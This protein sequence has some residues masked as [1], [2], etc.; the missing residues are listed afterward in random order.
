MKSL[1]KEFKDFKRYVSSS[2]SARNE[3]KSVSDGSDGCGEVFNRSWAPIKKRF[4]NLVV[5]CG[6]VAT[7]FPGTATVQSDFSNIHLEADEYR[8]ALL[9]LKP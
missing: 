8:T 1:E 7:T 2:L 4:P 6:D 9:K 3:L 5:F